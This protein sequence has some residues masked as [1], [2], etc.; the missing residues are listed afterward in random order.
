MNVWIRYSE[1]IESRLN[2]RWFRVKLLGLRR[3]DG[4]SSGVL[5]KIAPVKGK[6]KPL[7][8]HGN[9]T[10]EVDASYLMNTH[11]VGKLLV[12]GPGEDVLE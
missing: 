8:L 11:F 7:F 2:Y 9:E 4:C 6:K 1:S 10:A 3:S 5:A 12:V